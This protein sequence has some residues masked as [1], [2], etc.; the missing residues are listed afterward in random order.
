MKVAFRPY[1][2]A[3][4]SLLLAAGACA[5]AS[6][7]DTAQYADGP[8]RCFSLTNMIVIQN[9]E[10]R[11]LAVRAQSN[12]AVRLTT[13][14]DCLTD[15]GQPTY[16]FRPLGGIRDSVCIGDPV[17]IDLQ[18]SSFGAR[19]CQATLAEVL[20]PSDVSELSSRRRP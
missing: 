9:S 13:T 5:P 12:D 19:T 8:R 14:V 15:R 7:I 1:T 20:T 10:A 11:S 4:A 6:Q 18:D 2:L 17:R 3:A 16:T